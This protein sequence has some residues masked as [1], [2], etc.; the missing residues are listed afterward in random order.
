MAPYAE[1]A[2]VDCANFKFC[3][4]TLKKP[5][6]LQ[7]MSLVGSLWAFSSIKAH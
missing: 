1:M 7:N 5:K 6:V 3:N 2:N 4:S